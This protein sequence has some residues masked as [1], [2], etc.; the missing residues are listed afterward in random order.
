MSKQDE[1]VNEWSQNYLAIDTETTGLD[2]QA[3]VVEIAIL[4]MRGADTISSY[5]TLLR[6]E[7]VDWDS[8]PVKAAMAVNEISR[9]EMDAAPTFEQVVPVVIHLLRMAPVI[10]GHNLRFD[11]RML[12][13]EFRRVTMSK[14]LLLNGPSKTHVDLWVPETRFCTMAL[15]K[16]LNPDIA[17]RSLA[18]VVEKWGLSWGGLECHSAEGDARMAGRV[19]RAMCEKLPD[20]ADARQVMETQNRAIEEMDRKRK[21]TGNWHQAG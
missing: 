3:R 18:K 7:G 2:D 11:L 14:Y 10:V 4:Q 17:G 16:I 8:E 5:S 21:Q 12:E 6:P 15:D 13:N 9:D 20:N 19:F 1:T